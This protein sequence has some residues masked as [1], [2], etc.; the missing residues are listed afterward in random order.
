MNTT[1]KVLIVEDNLITATDIYT[2]LENYGFCPLDPIESGEEVLKSLSR[3]DPQIIIM[4]INLKGEMDGIST[5]SEIEKKFNIP[6]IFLTGLQDE[7]ILQRAKLTNPY[8][9]LI[10]PFDAFE[11]KSCIELTLHRT[12]S[13]LEIQRKEEEEEEEDV[14]RDTDRS[15]ITTND[16]IFNFLQNIKLFNKL[17]D[18]T[19]E[20]LSKKFIVRDIDAGEFLLF[21]GDEPEGVFIPISGRICV[22]KT[23]SSGKELI[24]SLLAPGDTFGLFYCL[25]ALK[26][27]TSVRTQY[28]TKVLW[29]PIHEWNNFTD[30]HPEIY[31]ELSQSL[32]HR[33][34]S[35][36]T[37]SSRLAHARVE[38][39]IINTLLALLQDFGRKN[40]SNAN[41]EKIFITRKELA[42]LTG[43]TPETA[44]RIT[45]SL[46]RDKILDLSRPGIIKIPDIDALKDILKSY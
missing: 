29:L 34:S 13:V 7:E 22:T 6:I 35:A 10:K 24:V 20:M 23:S 15:S 40:Q 26:G 37:L 14:L 11:L 5:A 3:L 16:T 39:R 1:Q 46:E 36:Y 8:G 28:E 9:Y 19:L 4:D 2:T 27:A 43:T 12:Q 38:G 30:N 32:A 44:I 41:E 17:N 45:K 21:E 42:E 18:T 33:L 25:D 31:K